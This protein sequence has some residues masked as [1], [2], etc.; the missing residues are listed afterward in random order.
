MK[1][2]RREETCLDHAAHYGRTDTVRI[3]LDSH[4]EMVRSALSQRSY[5]SF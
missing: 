1:D 3:L 2:N 5:Y 4:P